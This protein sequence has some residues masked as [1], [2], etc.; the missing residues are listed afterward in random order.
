MGNFPFRPSYGYSAN[1]ED[2][3]V[4][5]NNGNFDTSTHESTSL[6]QTESQNAQSEGDMQQK[7]GEN[8]KEEVGPEISPNREGRKREASACLDKWLGNGARD[9]SPKKR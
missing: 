3:E 2:R 4:P 6:A 8:Q 1:L 7:Q 9:F 5:W